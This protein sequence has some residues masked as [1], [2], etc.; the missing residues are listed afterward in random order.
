MSRTSSLANAFTQFSAFSHAPDGVLLTTLDATI[1]DV[2]TTL[3]EM[4]GY[5]REQLLRMRIDDLVAPEAAKDVATHIEAIRRQGGDRFRS[6]WQRCDGK[7]MHVE[8]SATS[9]EDGQNI[10]AF[11]RDISDLVEARLKLERSQA[12][13]AYLARANN[14]IAR[15]G[16]PAGI[17]RQLCELA[18]ELDPDIVLAWIGLVDPRTNSVLVGA[19]SGV[20]KAYLDQITI[21]L[22]PDVPEGLGPTACCIRENRLVIVNHFQTESLTSPWHEK[23]KRFGLH[24][25]AA[26]PFSRGG[27]PCGALMLYSAADDAFD[28]DLALLVKELGANL[29]HALDFI[30]QRDAHEIAVRALQESRQQL[31]MALDSANES[32]WTWNLENGQA[33]WSSGFYRTLGYANL[34]F[35][36]STEEWMS[37]MHP[38]DRDAT[39]NGIDEQLA[40][41]V[42]MLEIEFRMRAKNGDWRW[43]RGRGK[44]VESGADGHPIKLYGTNLD[45]TERREN[46]EA[47]L[48]QAERGLALIRFA[49]KADYLNEEQLLTYGLEEAERLT[50]SEMGFLHFVNDDQETLT[51]VT[52]TSGALTQCQAAHDTHYPISSAGIWADAFRERRPVIVND[53][54]AA[55]NKRGL[56][57]GHTQLNRLISV[58]V[59]ENDK[60]KVIA[61]VGNKKDAYHQDDVDFVQLLLTDL[62]RIVQRARAER[63]LRD[64]LSVVE[65]S[66][67]VSF[68]WNAEEGWPVVYV[69]ANISRWGYTPEQMYAGTPQFADLVHP[70]DLDR[71]VSQMTHNTASGI[72]E[73]S[74]E[75]RVLAAEGNYFW[76]ED[77]THIV[78]DAA[79]KVRFYEGVI[80][81]IHAK[82]TAEEAVTAALAQ[83]R[84]LNKKLEDA[85]N[86]LLQSEKL[87]SIGQLAAGVA[88]ELNNPIGFVHSNLGTLE[89]YL[90]D[91]FE[92]VHACE[93]AETASTNPAEF[94]HIDA[95]KSEKDFDYLKT[96][97][98]ALMSESKDGLARVKKIVQDLKDF[99]RVGET[100]WQTADMHK[101]LDST[102][103]IVWNELKYKCTVVK[104][105]APDLPSIRCLPSQLNQVFMNLLVN[106]AHA[107]ETKGE[108]TISTRRVDAAN[109]EI[110]FDDNGKGIPP[111][112]MKHIFEPFF[113]TKPVGKGTG[114]GLSIAWGII[115]K[116]HGK[117]EVA[118]TVG[119]GTTFTL[120]LPLNPGETESPAH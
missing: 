40:R 21:S 63:A 13:L 113:T 85:Q 48:R 25:S 108:I 69:S 78:R 16:D 9:S 59:I 82:K 61:G 94:A 53:Y 103:N 99:S 6:Q 14:L 5:T 35:P 19:S 58:P 57:Q 52:W 100:E 65:A 67:V 36:A 105:Y 42:D 93:L 28:A 26:M 39:L 87:A 112:N 70:D 96:D 54:A 10:L 60:V 75:Y 8:I 32:I 114:L 64:A 97:V 15:S 4:S 17:Y 55:N 115:G 23:A 38:D 62:W 77:H 1:I 90:V 86:Q 107:I 102:L 111:E 30:Q 12:F 120:T 101:G 44:V 79:G 91:I 76:V 110:R 56:P 83:Q 109:I 43:M 24:A 49:E 7:R 27:V 81:D 45:I 66:P 34:E 80:N 84:K 106:A 117:I 119:T 46:E 2:N 20:A 72:D 11:V 29:S 92:I 98:A 33:Y 41:H 47:N 37:H 71:V 88:H 18:T 104:H 51:L 95:L 31:E 89:S 22:D 116:H 74:Q 118:S 3:C 68:R 73:F 50:G